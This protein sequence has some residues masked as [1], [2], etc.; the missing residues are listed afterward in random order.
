MQG[1]EVPMSAKLNIYTY[2]STTINKS[3]IYLHLKLKNVDTNSIFKPTI[4][5]MII[6]FNTTRYTYKTF[7]PTPIYQQTI[8]NQ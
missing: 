4:L 1:N 3:S 7:I 8:I 6:K 5:Y 2:S